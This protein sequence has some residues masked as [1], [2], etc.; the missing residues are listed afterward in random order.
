MADL[1]WRFAV[2]ARLPAAVH[3]WPEQLFSA[4]KGVAVHSGEVRSNPHHGSYNAG[5]REETAADR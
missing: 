2:V 4:A 3:T 1:D 5:S